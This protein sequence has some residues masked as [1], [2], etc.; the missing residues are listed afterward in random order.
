MGRVLGF[1]GAA[2]LGEM[3]VLGC[4]GCRDAECWGFGVLRCWGAWGNGGVGM[5]GVLGC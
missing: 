1:W 2:V 5:L 3:E 4:W